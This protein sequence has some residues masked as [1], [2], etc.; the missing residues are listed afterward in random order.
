MPDHDSV[1]LL[2]RQTK[3]RRVDIGVK[4]TVGSVI[5][6]R[7]RE[8]LLERINQSHGMDQDGDCPLVGHSPVAANGDGEKSNVLR[9]LLKRANSYEDSMMPF[10]GA[11][12]ISQ[13][14]K[15]NMGKNGGSD[16]G[17]QVL[18]CKILIFLDHSVVSIALWQIRESLSLPTGEREPLQWWLRDP[19]R[20]RLQQLF[21]GKGQP[22][23][24]SLSRASPSSAALL[25]FFLVLLR[26]AA[27]TQFA[28]SFTATRP[29]V[30]RLGPT[31]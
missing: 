20:G 13:L 1:A 27:A 12:I 10:P 9:K 15:S 8:T 3:R 17:F 19:G 21:P 31:V 23:R 26:E 7:N 5:F 29:L 30:L 25:L 16:S 11:T 22:L 24:L 4:R 28:R 14:L 2:T 18:Y 6:A